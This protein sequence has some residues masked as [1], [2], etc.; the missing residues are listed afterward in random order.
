MSLECLRFVSGEDSAYQCLGHTSGCFVPL[1][2]LSGSQFL[3]IC[4][5]CHWHQLEIF[6]HFAVDLTGPKRVQGLLHAFFI[7]Y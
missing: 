1:H 4:F 6:R 7:A 2:E 5:V 3:L